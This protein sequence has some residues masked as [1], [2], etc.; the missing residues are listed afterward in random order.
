M[1]DYYATFRNDTYD[2][3]DRNDQ[4][5]FSSDSTHIILFDYT[6]KDLSS[7]PQLFEH[8]VSQRLD[9]KTLEL[10][11]CPKDDN[12]IFNIQELLKSAHPYYRNKNIDWDHIII[13]EIGRYFNNLLIYN[14][15][16]DVEKEWYKKRFINLMPASLKSI[17]T[18]PDELSFDEFHHQYEMRVGKREF[19]HEEMEV[20]ITGVKEK[21][22]GFYSIIIMQKALYNMLHFILDISAKG[23]EALTIPQRVWMYANIFEGPEISILKLSPFN[24]RSYEEKNEYNNRYEIFTSLKNL[25][26]EY[27]SNNK[28]PPELANNFEA[29]IEYTKKTDATQYLEKYKIGSLNALLYQEVLSMIQ[30]GII[31]KKCKNCNRYFVVTNRKME[32]CNRI[33]KGNIRCS[34]IGSKRTFEKKKNEE[35]ALKIYDRAYKTHY[36]RYMKKKITWPEFESWVSE[37]KGKLAQ[38]RSGELDISDFQQWIKL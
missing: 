33:V 10:K 35:P 3:V 37:A 2:F 30:S 8:Y 20:V 34:D 23:L 38:V 12:D 4:Y 19:E 27:Y 11:D 5:I 16:F 15:S 1:M 26:E 22:K 18:L 32:Y 14:K 28:I 13:S 31:I 24:S 6:A 36:A 29:A 9:T 7:L 21:P 17:D 25:G